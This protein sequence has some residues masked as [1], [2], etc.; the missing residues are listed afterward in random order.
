M[1]YKES[2]DSLLKQGVIK[3]C[4]VDYKAIRDL[5]KRANKDLKTARRNLSED[6]EC[7]YDCAYNAM[8]RLGLALMSSGGFRPDIKN[9]HQNIVKYVSAVLG[10][11]YIK[12]INDYDFMRRKRNKF[13]Y[14]PGIPCSTKEAEDAI[15]IAEQFT[16]RIVQLIKETM[17]QKEFKF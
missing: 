12:L 8:L 1:I 5:V 4:P 15:K 17:P 3:R 2:K 9:K 16:G 13:L 7:A 11:E 10:N 14:E 6:Q